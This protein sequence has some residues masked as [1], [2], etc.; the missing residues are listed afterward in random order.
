MEIVR[1]NI[2]NDVLKKMSQ[3][4]FD[5][6]VKAVIDVEQ[7]IMVVDAGMH[8]DEEELLLNNGASQENLWGINLHPELFGTD[9]FIEFDSMI[10]IRPSDGN[11][12]RS[13]VNKEIQKKIKEIITKLVS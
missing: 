13:V 8:S 1:E 6:L 7:E 12:S 4:M 11:N 2:S 5:N 10:N 3:K 9:A